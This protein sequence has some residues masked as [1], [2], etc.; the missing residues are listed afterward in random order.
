MAWVTVPCPDWSKRGKKCL[1]RVSGSLRSC[2]PSWIRPEIC[3]NIVPCS[4]TLSISLLSFPT[5]RLSKK[6]WLSCT[7]VSGRLFWDYRLTV[8]RLLEVPCSFFYWFFFF[9]SRSVVLFSFLGND[10]KVN[11]LINFEKM[12]MIAKE[13]RNVCRLCAPDKSQIIPSA[14]V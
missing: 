11:G 14:V 13:V 4:M 8:L 1:Q 2:K 7:W 12:R 5:F 3:P 6:I 9:L 10:T